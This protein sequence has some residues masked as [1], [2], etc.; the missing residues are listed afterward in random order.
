MLFVL[1]ME[2]LFRTLQ[3][4]ATH[5]NFIFHPK[6]KKEMVCNLCFANDLLIY[7]KGIVSD[8]RY[9]LNAC[10]AF[11]KVLGLVANKI[12]SSTYFGGVNEGV[13]AVILNLVVL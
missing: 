3:L 10:N 2:Y 11:S 6:Y 5:P 4:S 12:K 9:V 8:V 13:Q 7:C 1:V